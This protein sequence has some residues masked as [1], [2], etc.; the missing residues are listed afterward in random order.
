VN[1]F[2]E[3]G[4][5]KIK[6]IINDMLDD[7]YIPP[8]QPRNIKEAILQELLSEIENLPPQSQ[9]IPVSERLPENWQSI[10][11][12]LLPMEEWVEWD[13]KDAR[14]FSDT[15]WTRF[16]VWAWDFVHWMYV[17]HKEY[18]Q[19]DTDDILYKLTHWQPLPLPP[20]N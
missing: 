6:E 18:I 10:F 4:N 13:I 15:L 5:E 12:Y 1:Q 20:N 3:W 7:E 11:V 17:K 16:R 14:F 9:W 19:R 8:W 2:K